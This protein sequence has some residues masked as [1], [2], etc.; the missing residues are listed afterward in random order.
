MS[1]KLT[2]IACQVSRAFD[3][4]CSYLSK[5]FFQKPLFDRTIRLIPHRKIDPCF[6]IDDAFGVG[7]GFKPVFSVVA[8]HA[9]F[10]AA[11]KSHVRGGEVDDGIVDTAAAKLTFCGH[12]LYIFF[13]F[14][15]KIEGERTF[16]GI[17]PGDCFIQCAVSDDWQERSEDLFLHD[18]IFK[19]HVVKK[20]RSDLESIRIDISAKDYFFRIEQSS[21]AFKMFLVYDLSVGRIF[22]RLTAELFRDLT[23]Q[24]ADQS[25]FSFSSQ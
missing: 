20:G 13:L 18:S 10:A 11:A 14:T 22:Q 19:G 1:A 21:D 2:R 5:H 17:D 4:N 3:L 15:E 16:H 9:A 12:F 6:F 25:L 24:F 8:S 23:F 7:E